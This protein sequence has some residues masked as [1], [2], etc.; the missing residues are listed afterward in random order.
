[1]KSIHFLSNFLLSILMSL[2]LI[3]GCFRNDEKVK[4]KTENIPARINDSLARV[5][6]LKGV[7]LYIEDPDSAFYC[8]T[9]GLRF[10]STSSSSDILPRLLYNMAMIHNLALNHKSTTL[11]L[12]SA[13]REAKRTGDSI[14]LANSYNMLGNIRELLGDTSAALSAWLTSFEIARDQE[15]YLQ[16]GVAW[17]NLAKGKISEE[18]YIPMLHESIAMINKSPGSHQELGTIYNNLGYASANPDTAIGYFRRAIDVGRECNDHEVIVYALNNMAYSYLEKKDLNLARA[19][20]EQE[21]IPLALHHNK[22]TWL[23]DL[24]D[25]YADVMLAEGNWVSAADYMKRSNEALKKAVS[26]QKTRQNQLLLALL[27]A[28]NRELVIRAKEEEIFM[29]HT[30]EQVMWLVIG[31][32]ALTLL[33]AGVVAFFIHQRNRMQTQRREIET[34]RRFVALDEKEKSRIARQLHDLTG[35]ISQLLNKQIG[36]LEFP[37]VVMKTEL[38]TRLENITTTLRHLSHRMNKAMMDQLSFTELI[39]GLRMDIQAMTDIP[40]IVRIDSACEQLPSTLSQHVYFMMLELLTN[41][42]KHVRTGD[43]RL[44]LSVEYGMLYL[45]Y[46]DK[47]PGFD[48]EA[49]KQKGMGLSNIMERAR[50]LKGKAEVLSDSGEGTRWTISIPLKKNL[51]EDA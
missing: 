45:I 46:R 17:S 35:P 29:Q 25:S 41:A 28:R 18:K 3:T 51:K 30:R 43:I 37:D 33:L 1:M 10:V 48:T 38:K 36:G 15:L 42:V 7:A 27:D 8:Y 14:T 26:D 47:G 49:I 2:P 5:F 11:F 32:L 20:L 13:I 22:A 23:A 34:A 24:F 16:M 50:L 31:L 39:E 21:A 4:Q 12:D 19:C 40:V 9:E 44:S 6:L